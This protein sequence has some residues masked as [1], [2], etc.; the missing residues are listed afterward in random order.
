MI[1][2]LVLGQKKATAFGEIVYYSGEI[3]DGDKATGYGEF[4]NKYGNKFSGHFV[5]NMLEGVVVMVW[6]NG[7]RY[8]G[9]YKENKSHGKFTLHCVNGWLENSV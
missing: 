4:T 5:N 3:L 7:D 1:I 9:E 6:S 2:Q 8:E